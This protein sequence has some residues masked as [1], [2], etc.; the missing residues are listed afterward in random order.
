VSEAFWTWPQYDSEQHDVGEVA[1]SEPWTV[2]GGAV[3]Y[4]YI[5]GFDVTSRNRSPRDYFFWAPAD[6]PFPR[7]KLGPADLGAPWDVSWCM[8]R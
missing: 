1:P 6:M 2:E 5:T 4:V 8:S 7:Y 3:R